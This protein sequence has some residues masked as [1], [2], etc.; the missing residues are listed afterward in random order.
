[1]PMAPADN[2]YEALSGEHRVSH[3]SSR[4]VGSQRESSRDVMASFIRVAGMV[5]LLAM[6]ALVAISTTSRARGVAA[7]VLD[8]MAAGDTSP[9]FLQ[10]CVCVC[11]GGRGRLRVCV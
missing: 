2:Q 4:E 5:V 8:N 3:I 10:V 7:V 9:L 6:C 11:G 1:M